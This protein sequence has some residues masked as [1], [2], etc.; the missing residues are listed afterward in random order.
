MANHPLYENIQINHCLLK[1]WEDKFIFFDIM[2]STVHCNANLYKFEGYA[3]NLNDGNLENDL[4]ATIASIGIEG[5]Y[6]NTGCIYR[7]IDNQHQNSTLRLLFI[8]VN[9]KLTVSTTD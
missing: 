3:T 1:T 6:I 7:N 9:I 5:E 2:D 4:N 8:I